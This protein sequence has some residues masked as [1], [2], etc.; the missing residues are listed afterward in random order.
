MTIKKARLIVPNLIRI[1]I[2][3]G[4]FLVFTDFCL[5]ILVLHPQHFHISIPDLLY[6]FLIHF[7]PVRPLPEFLVKLQEVMILLSVLYFLE[8]LLLV[9]RGLILELP[10]LGGI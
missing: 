7:V 1:A 8:N 10:V 9:S 6:A 2:L 3:L 5:L 4:H